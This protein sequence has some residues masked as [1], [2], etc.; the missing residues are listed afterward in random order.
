MA[1]FNQVDYELLKHCEELTSAEIRDCKMQVVYNE[2]GFT[3]GMSCEKDSI[4]KRP[5]CME[6]LC[7]GKAQ[8]FVSVTP[9]TG[10]VA[11][12]ETE[13]VVDETEPEVEVPE[14]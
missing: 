8:E 12:T 9:T 5:R 3:A 7:C 11:K 2:L 1:L 10:V 6:G 14:S 13:E 4:G